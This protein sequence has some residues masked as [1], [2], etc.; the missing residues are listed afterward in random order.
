MYFLKIIMSLF[1]VNTNSF[2]IQNPVSIYK[3]NYNNAI[4]KVYEPSNIL[5]KDM[6][7]IIFYSGANSLMPGDI[8]SNF[9]KA[10]NNFNFS[11]NVVTND[12]TITRELLYT[13]REEYNTVVPLSHSSGFVNVFKT[14][15]NQRNIVKAVFLDPVDNSKLFENNLMFPNFA[16]FFNNK[17][18]D[19]DKYELSNLK[20]VLIINAEK[21]YKWQLFPKFEIPFI[22]GFGLDINEFKNKYKNIEVEKIESQEFGHSDVLDTLWSDLMHSTISKGNE[23][24]EQTVLDE[25]HLWLAEK[26]YN[27]VNSNIDENIVNICEDDIIV[28]NNKII[29]QN[30]E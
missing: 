29:D 16:G 23:N 26:I 6:D 8:Y 28:Y 1:I 13:I 11:V 30:I 12:N 3:R 9:I 22:P 15:Y 27:F 20:N 17:E 5:K 25:Y 2:L 10:L 14:I 18:K 24:R 4:I 7:A 21:S 19:K